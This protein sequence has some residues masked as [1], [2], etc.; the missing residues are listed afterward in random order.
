MA[1]AFDALATAAAASSEG[2]MGHDG[3]KGPA[4]E[5]EDSL[6]AD[7]GRPMPTQSAPSAR[8]VSRNGHF[9]LA[10]VQEPLP[11]APPG[12]HRAR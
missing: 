1:L 7:R 9:S 2:K 3:D 8:T 12:R 11:A 6:P 10:G 4:D 5:G